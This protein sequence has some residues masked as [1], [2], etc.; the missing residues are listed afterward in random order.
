M[1]RKRYG[2][3]K[4]SDKCPKTLN[5]L[6]NANHCQTPYKKYDAITVCGKL[7]HDSCFLGKKL[8][9]FTRPKF[10]KG[11]ENHQTLV[12][13]YIKGHYP[14]HQRNTFTKVD[15][16]VPLTLCQQGNSKKKKG[17]TIKFL[18]MKNQWVTTCNECIKLL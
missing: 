18:N 8:N 7:F 3:R 11:G 10:K 16:E 1:V 12:Q 4:L 5:F 9:N 14:D 13:K 15:V 2:N 6:G 17:G